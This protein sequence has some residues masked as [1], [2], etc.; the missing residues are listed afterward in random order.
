[1]NLLAI[2]FLVSAVAIGSAYLTRVALRI[3]LQRNILDLPN[4]RSSHSVPTPR[5]GGLSLVFLFLCVVSVFGVCHLLRPFET[6]GLLAGMGIAA[7]GGWDDIVSLPILVRLPVQLAVCATAVLTLVDYRTLRLAV[8]NPVLAGAVLV[9]VWLALVWLVNLTNFMDGIDGLAGTE[10]V[11][12]GALCC[13]I[14]IAAYGVNTPAILFGVL[15]AAALG[16]L[17]WNWHPAAI[18]MGD[19]GSG[20][21]GFCFGSLALLA[22]AQHKLCVF[23]PMILLG[24]FIVDA[25]Y[26]LV[27]RMVN[28]ERWYA[29]HRSHSFQHLARRF[30]HERTTVLV[31]RV[32]LLW[33]GPCAA[34]A[35]RY[36][37]HAVPCVFVAWAALVAAAWWLRGGEPTDRWA[38]REQMPSAGFANL[39]L[40]PLTLAHTGASTVMRAYRLMEKHGFVIK[41]IALTVLNC[42]CVYLAMMTRFDS[43]IPNFWFSRLLHIAIIWCLVQEAVLLLF[44]AGRSHWRFT[45]AEE[46]PALSA[47][48]LLA[49]LTG[50]VVVA[51][52]SP[53]SQPLPHSIYLLQAI[54]SV[55]VLAGLRL[56]SRNLFGFARR[57]VRESTRVRVLIYG[58]DE[59][60]VGVL[61]E[62]RR[63]CLDYKAVGFVD[64]RQ[65]VQG[66]SLS[67]LPVLGK[68]NDLP[69]LAKR[70]RVN[71]VIVPSD[72]DSE[73]REKGLRQVC[74]EQKLDFRVVTTMSTEIRALR[75]RLTPELVIEDLLGRKPIHLDT[76]SI[77]DKLEGQVVMVTGAAGSIGSELCRQIARF[78]P[79]AI[80]GFEISE[81]ALFYMERQMQEL[82]PSIAFIPC[83]GSVQNQARLDDVLRTYRPDT[84]YHAAAY[85]HVPLMEQHIFEAIENNIFGTETLLKSC[86]RH[87][88]SSFVMISTDKAARPTSLMGV[89]KRIAEM[90]VRASTTAH[91]TCVSTRFGNVLGSNGSVIP[92]FR[93][94]IAKGGPVMITH[95]AMV[96]FFMTIHQ[97]AQLVLQDS[98]FGAANEIFVLDMGEPVKIVDLAEKMIRL[99]GLTPGKDIDIEFT[100][101]R[102]GEKL[103]EELSTSDE[104]LLPT[105][106]QSISVFRSETNYSVREL[107]SDL[108][109]LRVALD[110]RSAQDALRILQRLVPD[111]TASQ[112]ICA[113]SAPL[114]KHLQ[115]ALSVA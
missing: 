28:G 21:L 107:R 57:W 64:D 46:V 48:A 4:L 22:A 99:S 90:L 37:S 54:Y 51:M 84:V 35:Q 97:S 20:F 98:S 113:L 25:S 88:V 40:G 16:F 95:P 60:G 45:S 50:G 106:H 108:E 53:K 63:L 43:R 102:P 62:L 29:P 47:V 19:V 59:S 96:R 81:T 100:G 93:E 91:L 82:F 110:E 10:A 76:S 36:P 111:Y 2:S 49:S 66:L 11:T 1:M 103:I 3:A 27:R 83:I 24:V 85:K 14:S 78:R 112:E 18:F 52:L 68:E 79:R 65:T 33:L 5:A 23:V 104:E 39:S 17:L 74:L 109:Q 56:A 86:E 7:V 61:S 92:I 13:G 15:A 26:T 12:V 55:A 89:S 94:Q 31:A 44:K 114:S 69:R 34:V 6:V 30:G 87:G 77:A 101:M 32:N 38:N 58:A 42:G 73:E 67:G 9:L 115:H 41:H 70:Y 72:A 80:L 75:P 105:A 8:G 71:L